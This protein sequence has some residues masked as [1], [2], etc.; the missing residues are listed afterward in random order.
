MILL[1][2]DEAPDTS[3]VEEKAVHVNTAGQ[4]Q[5]T[6][7]TTTVKPKQKN[8]RGKKHLKMLKNSKKDKSS[9]KINKPE[10]IETSKSD[11][12]EKLKRVQVS[13]AKKL[14]RV[15][16]FNGTALLHKKRRTQSLKKNQKKIQHDTEVIPH[17]KLYVPKANKNVTKVF[18]VRARG[19][20]LHTVP[21]RRR[22]IDIRGR[23]KWKRPSKGKP[24]RKPV[25]STQPIKKARQVFC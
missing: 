3:E 17:V 16:E 10:V 24:L 21:G 6:L 12:D 11:D 1:A 13:A 7:A 4:V 15:K 14:L 2:E 19:R 20:K 5:T 25:K 9:E 8:K 23:R 22:L 18:G